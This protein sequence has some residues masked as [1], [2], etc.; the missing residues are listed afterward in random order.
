MEDK[1]NA[2]ERNTRVI[3][4]KQMGLNNSLYCNQTPSSQYTGYAGNWPCLKVF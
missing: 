1:N 2:R 3:D 4:W